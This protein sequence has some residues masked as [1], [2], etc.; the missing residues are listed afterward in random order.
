MNRLLE[1]F[2]QFS[3]PELNRLLKRTVFSAIGVGV[4]ALVVAGLLG[5]LVFGFGVC[6]GLCLGLVNVRLIT[7]QTAKVTASETSRPIRALASLTL[8][9]LGVTTVV[10][11]ILAVVATQL[12]LGAVG[13]VAL[14]YFTFLGNL[15]VPLLKKGFVA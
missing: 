9:R 5:H 3:L 8:F 14:F 11:V 2:E 6:L 12:G 13:G 15:I 1:V 4:V 10:I 7:A